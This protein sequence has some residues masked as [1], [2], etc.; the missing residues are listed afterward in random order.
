MFQKHNAVKLKIRSPDCDFVIFIASSRLA[1]PLLCSE[2]QQWWSLYDSRKSNPRGIQLPVHNT[3]RLALDSYLNKWT[4][5]CVFLKGHWLHSRKTK[6][7]RIAGTIPWAQMFSKM[8]LADGVTVQGDK[9]QTCLREVCANV[10][11]GCLTFLFGD[12]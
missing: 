12:G 9:S 2:I 4:A 6:T 10:F 8:L 7:N 3:S 11:D 5:S 1:V